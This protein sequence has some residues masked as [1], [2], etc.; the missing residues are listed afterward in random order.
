MRKAVCIVLVLLIVA[1]G[2]WGEELALAGV[3]VLLVKPENSW[4]WDSALLGELEHRGIEV[5]WGEPSMLENPKAL[6]LFDMIA[7]SIKR[8]FTHEQ[9]EGLKA[10]LSEGGSLYGSWGGPMGC[11]ELLKVCGVKRTHSVRIKGMTLLDS[12]LSQGIDRREWAYPEFAGHVKLAD[13]GRE[14]V[15]VEPDGGT[16]VARDPEGRSLGVIGRYGKGRTAVLGFGV[17]KPKMFFRSSRDGAVALDNLLRWLVSDSAK[18]RS[19]PGAIEV[20][21]PARAKVLSVSVNG[22]AIQDPKVTPYGSLKKIKVD[23]NGIKPG[24]TATIR[25]TYHPLTK[26]RNVETIL[27]LSSGRLTALETPVKA[28]EF[29][30]SLN[31]TMV[32]PL[33]RTSWGRAYYRC[34]PEDRPDEKLVVEYKGDWLAEFIEECHKRGIKV[35]GGI[36]FDRLTSL[37]KYPEVARI[38]KDGKKAEKSAVCYNNPKAQEYNLKT[39]RHLLDNYKLDGLILDD[40]FELDNHPCYCDY[41]KAQFRT[42]CKKH[43]QPYEDPSTTSNDSIKRLWIECKREATRRLARTVRA[44]A[45]EHGIPA[46]GWVGPGMKPTHLAGSFDFLGGMLYTCSPSAARG[47]LSVMGEHKYITLLWGLNRPPADLEAEVP[48]AIRAGSAIVGFWINTTMEALGRKGYR[49][50]KG[51]F[52]AIARALG[53][54][55]ADWFDFYRNNIVTGDARFVV[56]N[57]RLG[58][59]E[60]VVTVKNLGRK[61]HRRVDGKV[62]LSAIE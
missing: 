36:Y 12:P 58:R 61:I 3:R 42:Y 56:T 45:A 50:E 48:E 14:T 32:Q 43:G 18:P 7:T 2:V 41:C 33:L 29:L 27:H 22:V 6:A 17:E 53:R 26:A 25:V 21:L 9:V 30:A 35:I 23:V 51:A 62:D 57:A 16:T 60:L 24:E 39:I 4:G 11:P 31:A 20:N 13:T 15:V 1:S 40:N 52:E 55:E 47:P 8:R 49:M 54:A 37:K 44:I 5:T 10:Y 59:E 34:L 19:W 46:G 28:A 38:E